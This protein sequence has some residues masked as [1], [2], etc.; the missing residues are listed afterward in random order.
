MRAI[1]KFKKNSPFYKTGEKERVVENL[2][3]VHYS[4]P[5]PLSFKS[6]A[7][8]SDINGMGFSI[9]NSHIEDFEIRP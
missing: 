8:E 7:F 5:T 1:I 4:Y 6:T 9:N 3:E 2:T